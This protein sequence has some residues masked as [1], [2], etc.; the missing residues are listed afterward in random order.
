V[1]LSRKTSHRGSNERRNDEV[2]KDGSYYW[3]WF[4]MLAIVVLQNQSFW[5]IR[6]LWLIGNKLTVIEGI[7]VAILVKRGAKKTKVNRKKT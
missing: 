6:F 3:C 7:T 1:T 4:S 5:H 2:S